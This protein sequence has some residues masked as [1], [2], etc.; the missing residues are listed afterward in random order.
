MN[1]PHSGMQFC[2][3]F[4]LF[5]FFHKRNTYFCVYFFVVVFWCILSCCPLLIKK[6]TRSLF[7]TIHHIL[8]TAFSRPS[9]LICL[10]VPPP[11]HTRCSCSRTH[12]HYWQDRDRQRRSKRESECIIAMPL[13]KT[14]QKLSQKNVRNQRLFCAT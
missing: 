2:P 3:L 1:I 6:I 14:L 4:F 12:T 9:V 7:D 5:N 11:N 13:Q 10:S 8:L